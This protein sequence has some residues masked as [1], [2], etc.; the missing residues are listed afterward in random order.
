MLI[1][2]RSRT[3]KRF[4]CCCGSVAYLRNSH[5]LTEGVAIPYQLHLFFGDIIVPMFHVT[6]P[7]RPTRRSVKTKVR[8]MSRRLIPLL[9]WASI[10][11]IVTVT[12]A[13]SAPYAAIVI[14]AD[15]GEVLY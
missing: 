4:I 8:Q 6:L 9:K 2:I 15:S 14:D 13:L 5:S 3:P 11:F 7:S 12:A 1:R 10:L